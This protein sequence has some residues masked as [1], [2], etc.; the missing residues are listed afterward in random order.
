MQNM[1]KWP[2]CDIYWNVN[3]ILLKIFNFVFL[4]PKLCNAGI[5]HKKSFWT[6]KINNNVCCYLFFVNYIP[7]LVVIHECFF[8][9]NEQPKCLLDGLLVFLLTQTVIQF[10]PPKRYH[11]ILK[12]SKN[13][14]FKRHHQF[15]LIQTKMQAYLNI[16]KI[17]GA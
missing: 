14:S 4:L 12:K 11:L 9:I 1:L 8:L 3:H 13:K 15:L 2:Q 7:Q 5:S 17:K 6:F 10:A 16:S